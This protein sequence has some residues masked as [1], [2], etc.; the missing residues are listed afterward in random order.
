MKYSEDR[1]DFNHV[2]NY[3]NYRVITHSVKLC[4]V[5]LTNL[6]KNEVE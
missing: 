1:T 3:M 2:I 6:K 4:K 5:I